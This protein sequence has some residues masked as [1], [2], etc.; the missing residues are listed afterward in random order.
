M[1]CSVPLSN[2][3]YQKTGNFAASVFMTICAGRRAGMW[4]Y[5]KS[6]KNKLFLFMLMCALLSA[7]CFCV[8]TPEENFVVY[9]DPLDT[10][11]DGLFNRADYPVEYA[12]SFEENGVEVI[13]SADIIVPETDSFPSYELKSRDFTDQQV[14]QIVQALYGE[15]IVYEPYKLTKKEIEPELLEALEALQNRKNKTEGADDETPLEFYESALLEVQERYNAAPDA[16]SLIPAELLL[17][18]T[19]DGGSIFSC[20]GDLKKK[21]F[22]TL[23]IRNQ[24]DA[25][26]GQNSYLLFQNPDR[27]VGWSSAIHRSPSMPLDDGTISTED[28]V[29]I[30]SELVQKMGGTD[31]SVAYCERGVLYDETGQYDNPDYESEVLLISFTRCSA[32]GVSVA[33]DKDG[34][35]AF[36][37]WDGPVEIIKCIT[38]Q[39]AIMPF[40]KVIQY[41]TKY[42]SYYFPVSDVL[43]AVNSEGQAQSL[44][45]ISRGSVL[46]C[47]IRINKLVLGWMQVSLGSSNQTSCLIPVWDVFGTIERVYENGESDVYYGNEKSLL[48]IDAVTGKSISRER[49]Y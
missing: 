1:L 43:N 41:V 22:A 7:L 12:C 8:P 18:P 33:I 34:A 44:E 32:K 23:R 6:K 16:D 36:A 26:E 13:F 27:Y 48:T 11:N 37:E 20:R 10:Q 17:K 35:V 3:L 49:G 19:K 15:A 31:M 42:L 24:G 4:I 39:C 40:E 21:K 28:A 9:N 2:T 30:A 46:S 14:Q 25:I 47:K 45:Q 29:R 5:M 38:E